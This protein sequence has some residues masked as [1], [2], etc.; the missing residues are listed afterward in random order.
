[1]RLYLNAESKNNIGY[2]PDWLKVS[3]TEN[4]E[5]L[6]LTLDIQGNIDYDDTCLSCRCKGDLI[7]WVLW[8]CE[9]GDE[10]DLSSLTE[11]EIDAMLPQKKIA[12]IICNSDSFEVGIYPVDDSEDDFEQAEDD[13]LS[14]CEGS[15]EIYVDENHHYIKDFDFTTELN[16]Y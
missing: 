8:N 9:T 4:G 14:N 15:I 6:E 2:T 3:Y 16:I 11:E 5:D 10:T 12:E 13:V 1:M 7:P